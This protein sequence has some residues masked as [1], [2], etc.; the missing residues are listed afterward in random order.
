MRVRVA[1]GLKYCCDSL[2]G[3]GREPVATAGGPHG[4]HCDLNAAA[5]AILETNRHRKP[6]GQLA[7]DLAFCGACADSPP[8][9]EVGDE[10]RGDRIEK[11]RAR[12]QCEAQHI[13]E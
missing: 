8:A 9:N 13:E 7:V 1:C 2:L 5:R 11:F 12:G 10:L 4:V 3:H 6:R